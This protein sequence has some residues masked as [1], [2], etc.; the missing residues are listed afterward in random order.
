M[1]YT[2]AQIVQAVPTG[3]NS[4]LVLISSTAFTTVAS[5][6][7][8]AN[9]FSATYANYLVYIEITSAS[10][11][12]TITGRYRAAGTDSSTGIYQ[13]MFTRVTNVNTTSIIGTNQQTSYSLGGTATTQ[14]F[15]GFI[16]INNPQTAI[17]STII[18]QLNVVNSGTSQDSL[19]GNGV[20][21]DTTSFDSFSFIASTGTIT[22]TVRAYGYANS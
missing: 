17:N 6:S 22:G 19:T 12:Q 10:A 21:G 5:V 20:Y 7:L 8:P 14:P 2:S 4:A 9:T 11:A 16:Q 13:N 18:L 1:A 3:I 15:G